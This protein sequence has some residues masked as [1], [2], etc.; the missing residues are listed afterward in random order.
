MV[1]NTSAPGRR[2]AR[3]D[4][5]SLIEVMIVALIMGAVVGTA[6]TMSKDAQTV[7][8]YE[9]NDASVQQEARFALDWI[10]TTLSQAGGNPYNVATTAC[11]AAGTPFAAFRLDPN[12]NGIQDDVRVQA[13]AGLP[14]GVILGLAGACNEPNEDV[15]IA[16][17]P[18]NNTLT[19]F[20]RA[21]DGAAVSVTDSV[22][23]LL[24]FTYLT[25][26]RV[27]TVNPNAIAYIQV[28]LNV[29][30]RARNERTGQFTTFAYQTEIRARAR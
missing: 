25:A 10:T 4:G 18:A 20:D 8:Q 3:E 17:N 5:F 23:T 19:R 15:T 28:A 1:A 26:G 27:A 13:D 29:R 22:F 12:G 21:T 2:F 16:H 30:S 6:V 24:Q 9:L 14:N 7:Y 11:P